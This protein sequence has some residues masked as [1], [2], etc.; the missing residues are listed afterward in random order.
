MISSNDLTF[1]ELRE[2]VLL[3]NKGIVVSVTYSIVRIIA[4]VQF[5]LEISGEVL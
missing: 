2:D 5:E 4:D 3:T 1:L